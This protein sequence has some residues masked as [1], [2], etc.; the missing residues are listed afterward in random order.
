VAVEEAQVVEVRVQAMPEVVVPVQAILARFFIETASQRSTTRL[1]LVAWV[2]YAPTVAREVR[3]VRQ[4]VFR[5][6]TQAHRL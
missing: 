3:P 5:I 1:E 4:E 6:S 2:G